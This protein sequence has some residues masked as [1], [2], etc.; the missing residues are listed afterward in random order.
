VD[1]V[2]PGDNLW[3]LATRYYHQGEDWHEIYDANKGAEQPDGQR[4]QNPNLIQPGWHLVIP[5]IP[6]PA[7]PGAAPNPAMNGTAPNPNPAPGAGAAPRPQRPATAAPTPNAATGRPAPRPGATPAHTPAARPRPGHTDRPHTVGIDLPGG[8]GY[9]GIT[10]AASIAAAVAILRTRNRHR[11][12][13]RD[14]QVPELSRHLAAVHSAAVSADRY[15]YRP[16]E[17]PGQTPPPLLTDPPGHPVVGTSSDLQH[18]T[19]FD[20]GEFSGPIALTG[21]GAMDAARALAIS[22]LA[23]EGHTLRVDP[24]LAGELLGTP[25][26]PDEPGWLTTTPEDRADENAPQQPATT[27]R[28]IQPG[29]DYPPG[30]VLLGQPDSEDTSSP[31]AASESTPRG[32]DGTDQDTGP[33]LHTLTR[34]QAAELYTTL[35]EARPAPGEPDEEQSE[36]ETGEPETV[37][38]E[39]G[40]LAAPTVTIDPRALTATPLILRLFGD[41][42]VLGP[43]G[44]TTP[45]GTEQATALLTLLALHTEGI[46]TRQLRALEWPDADDARTVRVTMSKAIGRVREPLRKALNKAAETADPVQHDSATGTYRLNPAVVTTDLALIEHLTAQAETAEPAQK[47]T[48]LIQAA[49]LYR[50]QLSP[51][52][53]DY[54]RDWLTT[55][56][57]TLLN[58]AATIHLRI[59]ELAVDTEPETAAHHLRQLADLTPDE[60]D[61]ITVALRRCQRL[62]DPR[63]ASYIY[64]RHHDA[65]HAT[66]EK[67]DPETTQLARAIRA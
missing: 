44:A 46:R 28:S 39:H 55:A 56:R 47:L 52:L 32:D 49:S 54:R 40:Q 25:H 57:H 7:A 5:P 62:N 11:G 37:S 33:R 59:A 12:L 15:G 66:N 34:D 24:E 41:P 65:L 22:T 60:H 21:P 6:A 14:H 42:D 30:T 3:N 45:I 36:A 1:V 2:E 18:E 26:A 16:D 50:G 29:T 48:L 53:D 35:R 31:D 4:L 58:G 8:A 38:T 17:H 9:I 43:T 23:T 13:P 64:Q 10:L 20:P 67:P 51:G 61:A 63:L 27:I 19:A